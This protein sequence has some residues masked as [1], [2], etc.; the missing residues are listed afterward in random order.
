MNNGDGTFQAGRS[1]GPSGYSPQSVAVGDVN[2]DGKPD[3]L[4]VN[5]CAS[6]IDCT[7]GSVG[8]FLGNGDGTFRATMSYGSGGNQALSV[9]VADVNGDGKADLLVANQ[10]ATATSGGCTSTNGSVGVLLGNGDGT[11]QPAV[12]YNSG[13]AHS[14][15]VADVNGDG[16]PDLIVAQGDVGVLLGN[17]DGTFQPEVSYAPGAGAFSVTVADVN[18]DG[19]LDL[20]VPNVSFSSNNGEV[21]VLLGNGDGTFQAP[22]AYDSGGFVPNFVAVA[23]VNGDGKLDLIVANECDSNSSGNC[24]QKTT[25]NVGVLLG[26]GDGT[27]QGVTTFAT[28]G[29]P[30]GALAVADF[31]GDGKLDIA[32]GNADSLLL[33]NGDGTFQAPLR[34]GASGR[35]IAV[36]DF[37]RDGRPD[38]SVGGVAVL[39]NISAGSNFKATS[40]TSL[41]SS[42]NPSVSGKSVRFTATVSSSVA[43]TGKVEFLNG[44]QVLATMKL[45]SSSAK[46]STSKLPAGS[47]T[48]TAVYLGDLNH[49]GSTSTPVNQF[50][51][52]ATTTTLTS[53]PNPSVFGRTVKFTAAVSSGIGAPPDGETV[54]FKR[55]TTVLGTGTLSGGTATLSVSTLGVGTKAITA[56]YGGDTSF[57]A[58]TSKAVSQVINKVSIAASVER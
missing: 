37:N 45:T 42:I 32:S 56:V 25:G 15:V 34:L 41:V 24:Y 26:N 29:L 18:G 46:Y 35:G 33:G 7:D 47:N 13:A 1:Y 55:G 52:E 31:N 9:A 21:G 22:T 23:D 57:A 39:L 58:S 8:V 28:I 2:G 17:G 27:F 4:V 12:T 36:G 54:T 43:P 20:L 16:K 50:V 40:T 11:F 48:I 38:L 30:Y 51:F 44:T 10:C 6:E 49:S 53:S 14:V 5:M 3:L 19:K